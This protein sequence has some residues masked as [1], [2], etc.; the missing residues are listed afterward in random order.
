MI[1]PAATGPSDDKERASARAGPLVDGAAT[2][3]SGRTHA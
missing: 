3:V 2:L 1:F